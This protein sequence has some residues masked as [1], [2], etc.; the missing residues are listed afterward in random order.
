MITLSSLTTFLGWCSVVNIG[1]LLLS[2]VC[3]TL[4]KG[5]VMNIHSK[6]FGIDKDELPFM[7]FEYLGQYKILIIVF[8]IV[9][10]IALKIMS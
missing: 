10:Y 6:I 8:N 5:P 9:P 7:Y 2:V 4:I 3:V 1:L